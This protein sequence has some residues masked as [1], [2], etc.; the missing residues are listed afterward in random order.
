MQVGRWQRQISST[1]ARRDPTQQLVKWGKEKRIF[2]S[3]QRRSRR[4]GCRGR[5]TTSACLRRN[6]SFPLGVR[7]LEELSRHCSADIVRVQA[8]L[9][10]ALAQRLLLALL[11]GAPGHQPYSVRPALKILCYH[12]HINTAFSFCVYSLHQL[13]QNKLFAFQPPH[14]F[15]ISQDGWRSAILQ[16]GSKRTL[17]APHLSVDF[18]NTLLRTTAMFL[19]SLSCQ[20]CVSPLFRRRSNCCCNTSNSWSDKFS[21]SIR[22]LRAPRTPWMSSS[23]FRWTA[24]ASRF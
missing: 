22:L 5:S 19:R 1:D 16:V 6:A 9:F 23:S 18:L 2:G 4:C 10:L 8:V 11:N 24:L 12:D 15:S 3:K 17:L 21:K 13:V 14:A 7:N 20:D